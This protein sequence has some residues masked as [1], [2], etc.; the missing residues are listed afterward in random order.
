MKITN[1]ENLPQPIYDAIAGDDYDRGDCDISITGLIRPA[2]IAAL[3]RIHSQELEEDAASRI[4]SLFGRLLHGVFEDSAKSGIQELRL[5]TEEL[6]MKVSGKFDHF[7]LDSG[8]LMDY[9][10]TSVWSYVFHKSGTDRSWEEQLNLYALLLSRNGYEVK[11][12]EIHA[13][14]RDWNASKVKPGDQYP[15]R[16]H[17][18]VEIK[19]WPKEAQEIFL[20]SRVIAHAAAKTVLPRCTNEERWYRGEVFAAMEKNKKRAVKLFKVQEEAE[21]F[22]RDNPGL[23]ID[24]RRGRPVRCEGNGTRKY[25][26]VWKWCTQY[27]EELNQ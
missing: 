14:L 19:L 15:D 26:S 3:E 18:R 13:F 7:D 23:W 10:L 24:Y 2:R 12:L 17:V 4:W 6:G 1:K 11:K 16:D 5:Y 25:C 9:K 8:T 20:R 22:V 21:Q 27:Q